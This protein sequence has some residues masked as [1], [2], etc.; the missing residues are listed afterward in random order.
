MAKPTLK[1]RWASTV[2]GDPTRYVEPPSGKKDVGWDVG[3]RPPAQYENW[4][5]GVTSDWV[6]W[7]DLY[8]STSHTW[9]STQTFTPSTATPGVIL[10]YNS[11]TATADETPSTAFKSGTTTLS[12]VD[13]LGAPSQRHITREYM[14]WGAPQL[15][16]VGAADTDVAVTG[17]TRLWQRHSG[18]GPA[19]S[20]NQFQVV[21]SLPE[22]GF[23]SPTFLGYRYLYHWSQFESITN[24]YHVVYGDSLLRIDA[25][26]FRALVME[27]S[28]HVGLPTAP[29]D[30][31]LA[32]GLLKRGLDTDA[33]VTGRDL[34]TATESLSVA[35]SHIYGDKWQV[36]Y[37]TGGVT[38]ITDTGVDAIA[39][40]RRVRIEIVKD[41][42]LGGPRTNVYLDGVN[43]YTGAAILG[44]TGTY[45]AF[46]SIHKP[47]S[48]GGLAP[49]CLVQ[50][51]PVRVLGLYG[52]I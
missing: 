38:T 35:T 7:L 47:V 15:T 2:T 8:E 12:V 30:A 17:E 9:T 6:D 39:S 19:V 11:T 29:A 26:N 46:S 33:G 34:L 24:Q 18:V 31:I 48:I 5:R 44:G 13:R 45:L 4:L 37:R 14:W 22:A 21:V 10:G 49:S 43:V 51:S 32:V 28:I 20:P 16:T 25:A 42:D 50:L 27:F 41:P 1:P 52:T 36:F 23:P 40:H 3:E